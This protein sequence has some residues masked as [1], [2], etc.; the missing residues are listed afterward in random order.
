MVQAQT[1]A[2]QAAS[3]RIDLLRESSVDFGHLE[4]RYGAPAPAL[5]HMGLAAWQAG[6]LAAAADFMQS[7]LACD[8]APAEIWRDLAFIFDALGRADAALGA[9]GEAL[10]R[11]D[12]HA[13]SWLMLG[14]LLPGTSEDAERALR[15]ALD[16]D[17]QLGEAHLALGFACVGTSRL[18]EAAGHLEA[19]I[20]L[21]AGGGEV[22]AVLGHLRFLSGQFAGALQ[23]FDAAAV[24][25]ALDAATFE[26]RAR[27][28]AF[29]AMTTGPLEAAAEAYAAEAGAGAVTP[30]ALLR[31]AFLYFGAQGHAQL[32]LHIGALC[33]ALDP[34]NAEMPYL[35]AAQAGNA[36]ERAPDTYLEA[37]FDRFAPDF[38]HKLVDLLGYDGPA[39]LC[40]LIRAVRPDFALMLDLGC[41]TGLAGADLRTFGGTL[42]GVDLSGQMLAQAAARGLYADLIKSE[43]LHYL[44]TSPQRYDLVLAADVLIYFGVLEP[45]FAGVAARLAPGGLFA[46]SIETAGPG[47]DVA[48]LP[49][50]RFVHNPDYIA[51]LA[52][53][54]EVVG[55]EAATVRQEAL[56]PVAGLFVVLRRI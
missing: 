3:R 55:W 43:A 50:G 49:S 51:R 32:A 13:R 35:L 6:D 47:V 26:K 30:F 17:P 9:I 19:A 29:L 10:A 56:K 2:F 54:F 39:H 24:S 28:R 46:F 5:R 41:G 52:A 21:G 48:V 40:R 23:A 31:E 34:A 33:L 53:G 25:G 22:H 14:R 15:R 12:A 11:D 8:A 4:A 37:Y 27:V 42:V 44:E 36:P 16:L 18:G 38:D 1:Q 45:L 20:R 7:A